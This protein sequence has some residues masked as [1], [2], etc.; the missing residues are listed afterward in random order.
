MLLA[1][2][3]VIRADEGF[4]LVKE[5]NPILLRDDFSKSPVNWRFLNASRW[6]QAGQYIVLTQPGSQRV[7]VTWLK[8]NITSPFTAEFRYK[9]GG[10]TGADGF[11][12]MFY[13][14][15]DYEPGIGGYLGFQCRPIT[16][17]CPKVE[18]PG[19]GLE[20]DSYYNSKAAY[21]MG[22]PSPKHIALLKDSINT[23]IVYVN[24]TRVS[25]NKWHQVKLV[26]GESNI[27]AYV[28]S[29]ETLNWSGPIN[30]TFSGI[31]FGSGIWGY[32]DWH[33][34]D[35]FKLYG[36]TITIK[37]VQPSWRTELVNGNRVL[38]RQVTA[39]NG[40]EAVLDITGL[41]MPLEGHLNVYDEGNKTIY[42]SPILQD[43][44]GGDVLT[45]QT[46]SASASTSTIVTTTTLSTT[47]ISTT[48]ATITTTSPTTVTST[49]A[50]HTQTTTVT[51]SAPAQTVTATQSITQ[52]IG[53]P[54]EIT[55][56][57]V[58]VAVMALIAAAVLAM[59]KKWKK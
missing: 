30:R 16:K 28:D 32:D 59:R 22:D 36:N 19:Y 41:A 56:A 29:S 2:S 42:A 43:I 38:A 51:S 34:I 57:A 7:G 15:T 13:K 39:T 12:F 33:I 37:G 5:G 31:G 8:R 27:T 1:L 45:L 55:Y 53:Q 52:T 58:A 35:D 54:S 18:A 4:T 3:A 25:D 10:G 11:V 26:V 14:D 17:P 44:W 20:F 47:L 40:T 9:V 23:H 24:D 48:T 46:A 49:L 6:D 50:P 21:N